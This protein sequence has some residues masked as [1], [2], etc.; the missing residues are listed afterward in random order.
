MQIDPRSMY[1]RSVHVK[2]TAPF[3]VEYL[4]GRFEWSLPAEKRLRGSAW[5]AA[6]ILSFLHPLH[7]NSH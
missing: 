6:G 2:V 1:P 3:G 5:L 4:A 7:N